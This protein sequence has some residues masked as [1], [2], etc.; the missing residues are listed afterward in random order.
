MRIQTRPVRFMWRVMV[1][2]AASI[3]RAVTRAGVIAFNP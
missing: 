1:R 2:R 3:W